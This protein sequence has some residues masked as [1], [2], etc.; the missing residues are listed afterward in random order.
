MQPSFAD[1]EPAAPDSI[2][3]LAEQFKV[4][5][6]PHKI[7]LAS[8]VYVD[9]SGTTPVLQTVSEAERRILDAQTTKLYKPIAGDPAYTDAVRRLIF[10]AE[11]AALAADR[12]ETLHTPGGTGALRVAADLIRRVRPESTV[13][14][15]TPTWPNH[16]QVFESAGLATRSYP[17]LD[18]SAATLD[19]DGLLG[20]LAGAEPGDVVVLHACCH[21]PSGV[22]PSPEDWAAIAS[23]IG[24]RGLWPLL[25][26]AYQG[27]GDG[28]LED[29]AGLVAIAA[30]APN[31]L[32][33][34]SFSKNFSLYNE[35]VGALSIVAASPNQA[36]TLLSHAKAVVRSNYSNPP[37]HGGEIVA[38]ILLDPALRARWEA[39]VTGMRTRITENRG[40]L[41]DGLAGAGA[42]LD[43]VPLKRQRGMF[44]L[45]PMTADQVARLKEEYGVYVVGRGRINVAGLTNANIG[46]ATAAIAEVLG[47]SR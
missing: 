6:R 1:L 29:A 4:D 26:F 21:N 40:R 23:I 8:G 5:A 38:T 34:S 16:P 31:V 47:E 27:F 30:A 41:V 44:S 2:L 37:A 9:E 12:V 14:L 7:S 15:S 39:E 22:D 25:D 33:A 13:W 17:Y 11:H 43:P 3:G 46:P 20:A 24:E 10:G 42:P 36:V 45:L 32:V 35:R 28:L 19:I 18:A